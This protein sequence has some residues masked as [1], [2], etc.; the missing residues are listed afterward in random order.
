MDQFDLLRQ[1]LVN[2]VAD[3]RVSLS[4]AHL[5]NRPGAGGDALNIGEEFLGKLRVAE[6]IKIFHGVRIS[7]HASHSSSPA[8]VRAEVAIIVALG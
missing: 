6:L 5:H 3:D 2:P 1:K 8:P 4:A 7:S